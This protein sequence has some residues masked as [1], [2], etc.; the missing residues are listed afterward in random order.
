MPD[1]K[2]ETNEAES[3]DNTETVELKHPS[4]EAEDLKPINCIRY[5]V[6][7][8]NHYNIIGEDDVMNEEE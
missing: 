3:S 5:S 2:N 7:H 4:E 8:K 1:D 6:V